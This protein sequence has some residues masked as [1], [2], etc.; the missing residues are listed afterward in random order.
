MKTVYRMEMDSEDAFRP[1]GAGHLQVERVAHPYGEL[2]KFFHTLVGHPWQWGGRDGWG[3]QE[4]DAYVN[5]PG[6]EMWL[7]LH[8]GTPVGYVELTLLSSEEV[9]IK[10]MGLAPAFIGK[11]LGG[12]LLTAAVKRAWELTS[13]KVWLSTCSQDHPRARANYEARG[14]EVV[15]VREEDENPPIPSFWDLVEAADASKRG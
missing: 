5:Q 15:T 13:K 9:Q 11:G 3:E 8:E 4:W 7:A 14:F 6:F 12:Q 10:R 1:G 2:S